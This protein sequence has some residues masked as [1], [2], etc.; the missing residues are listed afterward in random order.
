MAKRP[1]IV[2]PHP[3][4]APQILRTFSRSCFH[5]PN[6]NEPV[7]DRWRRLLAA[8]LWMG[9]V[10]RSTVRWWSAFSF[11]PV[12]SAEDVAPQRQQ[13]LLSFGLG[14]LGTSLIQRKLPAL[15]FA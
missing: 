1:Q 6:L 15:V 13:F 8:S 12:V 2:R 9:G 7:C 5:E 14:K 11:Q 3:A 4:M 10:S